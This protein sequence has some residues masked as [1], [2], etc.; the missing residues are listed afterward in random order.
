MKF[1]PYHLLA[2]LLITASPGPDNLMV[3]GMGISKAKG[4][5]LANRLLGKQGRVFVMVGDGELQ[6]GQKPLPEPEPEP[7]LRVYELR[8]SCEEFWGS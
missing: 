6:E 7:E 5:I 8:P 3:L 2:A 1:Q 4:M